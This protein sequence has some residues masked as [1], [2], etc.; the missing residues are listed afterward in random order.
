MFLVE[1]VMLDKKCEKMRLLDKQS[2]LHTILVISCSSRSCFPFKVIFACWWWFTSSGFRK[3]NISISCCEWWHALP[4][5]LQ[6]WHIPVY[7]VG[8]QRLT[9]SSAVTYLEQCAATSNQAFLYQILVDFISPNLCCTTSSHDHLKLRAST[10]YI[11]AG[12]HRGT[13]WRGCVGAGFRETEISCSVLAFSVR[14]ARALLRATKRTE[15]A[16]LDN[17][18]SGTGRGR[19]GEAGIGHGVSS[20]LTMAT[21]RSVGNCFVAFFFRRG[22]TWQ[23]CVNAEPLSLLKSNFPILQLLTSSQKLRTLQQIFFSENKK[24]V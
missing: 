17:W 7:L 3:R 8:F 23:C 15:Q 1:T 18:R 9:K 11:P 13:S 5:A 16:R 19:G 14:W 6:T 22:N 24:Q 21:R 2:Y 12:L 20:Q 10:T 4:S